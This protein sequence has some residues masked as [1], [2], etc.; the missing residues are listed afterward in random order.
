MAHS[1]IEPLQDPVPLRQHVYERLEDLIIYGELTAG[2]HLVES[3]LAERLGVS[4]IPVREALQQL[5]SN[6]WVELRPRFGAFVRR[7]TITEV[8]D[9][10]DVRTVLEAESARLAAIN[11]TDEGVRSLKETLVVG[12]EAVARNDEEEL[13]KLNS[14]FHRQVTSMAGNQVLAEMLGR[15]DKRMRWY[16]GSVASARG[17]AS[18]R[19]H[20]DLVGAIEAREPGRAAEVMR[21]HAELTKIAYHER[22]N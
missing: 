4:R 12:D 11:A 15:L 21:R 1:K 3:D 7:P 9:V 5:H 20:G 8:D 6:G 19:E 17:K 14:E 16:F 2:T 18:W 13:V 22:S 10:F